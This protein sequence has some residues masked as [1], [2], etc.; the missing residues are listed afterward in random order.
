[1]TIPSD[2]STLFKPQPDFFRLLVLSR[3]T[4]QPLISQHELAQEIGVS[5]GTANRYVREMVEAE[6]IQIDGTSRTRLYVLTSAGMAEL[7]A[8]QRAYSTRVLNDM[9]ELRAHV[10]AAFSRLANRPWSRIILAGSRIECEL[11]LIAATEAGLSVV[12]AVIE[13]ATAGR[14]KSIANAATPASAPSPVADD[15]MV[16]LLAG[17]VPV[18]DVTK[19]ATVKADGVVVAALCEPESVQEKISQA[20]ARANLPIAFL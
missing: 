7:R 3:L 15:E 16:A 12:A 19:M 2:G 8:L 10:R 14:R 4:R 20:A 11:A 13:S 6:W 1:M 18:L 17:L 5:D 9:A